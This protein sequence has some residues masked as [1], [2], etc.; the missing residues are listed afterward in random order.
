VI[1]ELSVPILPVTDST[2]VMPLIGDLDAARLA[3]IRDRALHAIGGSQ[4]RR[5][6]LDVTGVPIVDSQVAQG[7]LGVAQAA[8]LL[9]AE[10][11]LIGIRPEVAQTIVG[12][13]LDLAAFGT[14][15]DLRTAITSADRRR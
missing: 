11:V 4:A 3:D 12:L 5:L 9:G 2:L 10:V 13:G 14:A 8:R 15:A 7:L 1:R 6:L